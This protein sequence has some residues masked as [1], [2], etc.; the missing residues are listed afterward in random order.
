MGLSACSDTSARPADTYWP[1][2][3]LRMPRRPPNGLTM[4]FWAI[5][6]W[7]RF[8]AA[9]AVSRLARAVSRFASDVT[10]FCMRSAWRS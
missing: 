8:T 4:P 7:M 3:T 6:A 1:F 5:T 9:C 2:S 10:R